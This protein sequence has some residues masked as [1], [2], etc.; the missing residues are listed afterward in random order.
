[1]TEN[2]VTLDNAAPINRDDIAFSKNDM[3]TARFWGI[4]ENMIKPGTKGKTHSD[5][6]VA[7]HMAG[8]PIVEAPK[9]WKVPVTDKHAFS[10]YCEANSLEATESNYNVWTLEDKPLPVG[11]WAPETKARITFIDSDGTES[12]V[13]VSEDKLRETRLELSGSLNG[14]PESRHYIMAAQLNADQRPVSMTTANG[15]QHTI[16]EATED[17]KPVDVLAGFVVEWQ[18]KRDSNVLLHAQIA[19]LHAAIFT[20]LSERDAA[21][22]AL[23]AMTAERDAL[24]AAQD[25]PAPAKRASTRKAPAQKR[26][27]STST[28][29]VIDLD[30]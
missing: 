16:R 21:R 9:A 14:R 23:E 20:A 27:A 25:K 15:A 19:E 28:Q 4:R 8:R 7:W 13:D 29:A 17:D 1:M 12:T 3:S 5:V 26:A 2:T 24:I 10:A 22:S 6:L 11:Y 30:A 18:S